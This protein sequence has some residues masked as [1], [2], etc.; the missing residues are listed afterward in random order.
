MEAEDGRSNLQFYFPIYNSVFHFTR[1]LYR[2]GFPIFKRASAWFV[3][4]KTS[5]AVISMDESFLGW[6]TTKPKT[7]ECLQTHIK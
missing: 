4:I 3:N 7:I 5:G 1:H 6:L 2:C